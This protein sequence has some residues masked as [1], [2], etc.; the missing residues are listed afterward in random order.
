MREPPEHAVAR[1]QSIFTVE[2]GEAMLDAFH[3]A[4]QPIGGEPRRSLEPRTI[5]DVANCGRDRHAVITTL[6]TEADLDR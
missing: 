4:G 2:Q 5:A 1:D 3:G 6:R